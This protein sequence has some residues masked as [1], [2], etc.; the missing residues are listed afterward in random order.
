MGDIVLKHAK[1]TYIGGIQL[2]REAYDQTYAIH[3][4]A[5]QAVFERS[6]PPLDKFRP[7]SSVALHSAEDY[8]G[9]GREKWLTR[10]FAD[11]KI[12]TR[13]NISYMEFLDL[14]R[15]MVEFMIKDA[16]VEVNRSLGQMD[17]LKKQ[18]EAD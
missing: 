3:D 1:T 6:K 11:L 16:E 17:D 2:L 9:T 12:G 10:R 4:Y 5:R 8:I 15:W 14:P 18:I 7:L 13:F